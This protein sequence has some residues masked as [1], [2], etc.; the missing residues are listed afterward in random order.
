MSKYTNYI[1]LSAV[2]I[3]LLTLFPPWNNF[4]GG[5]AVDTAGYAFLFTPPEVSQGV[6]QINV[7]T[8]V[9]ECFVAL[10]IIWG[11]ALGTQN[12][13]ASR[14]PLDSNVSEV[15]S[16]SVES[17]DSDLSETS[18]SSIASRASNVFA[19][20]YHVEKNVSP[21]TTSQKVFETSFLKQVV[22][23]RRY[24]SILVL[25][26]V[27]IAAVVV[28][29]RIFEPQLQTVPVVSAPI[30]KPIL[31]EI[32]PLRQTQPIQSPPQ[33][34]RETVDATK[35][36]LTEM[37]D[38]HLKEVAQQQQIQKQNEIRRAR[39]FQPKTWRTLKT[40]ISGVSAH[41][42]TTLDAHEG[43]YYKFWLA[44]SPEVIEMAKSYYS[45]YT[46]QFLNRQGFKI[47]T[48][49]TYQPDLVSFQKGASMSLLAK[50]NIPLLEEEYSKITQWSMIPLNQ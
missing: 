29:R 44:G 7:T 48:F 20:S 8:L 41:L 32:K 46:V 35:K 11:L 25:G 45:G 38:K 23:D 39:L 16:N 9:V 27:A 36:M 34:S 15:Q 19:Y 42:Q 5:H 13:P 43:V 17:A 33:V 3:A 37:H 1:R 47:A 4:Y 18:E 28:G 30:E 12:S 22:E 24:F 40:S 14:K 10:A 50:G 21:S 31:S 6:A 26:L 2:A 49:S